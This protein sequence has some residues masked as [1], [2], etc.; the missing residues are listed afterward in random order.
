M[1]NS[2]ILDGDM[3]DQICTE[4]LGQHIKYVKKSIKRLK[5]AKPL[6]DFQKED[7]EYDT[8]ILA[9]LKEVYRYYGGKE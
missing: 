4:S 5:K 9:A 7:L 8:Y 1:S 2:I 3:V 6:E